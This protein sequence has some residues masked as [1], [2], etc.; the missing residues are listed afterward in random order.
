M[1]SMAAPLK[2]T[3]QV[4]MLSSKLIATV[5]KAVECEADLSGVFC[6]SDTK[7]DL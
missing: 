1:G 3:V 7:V 2:P 5:K 4:T 6:L